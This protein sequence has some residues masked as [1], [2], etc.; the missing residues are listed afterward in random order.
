MCEEAE[1]NLVVSLFRCEH[2]AV[3]EERLVGRVAAVFQTREEPFHHLV[4][5]RKRRFL[6]VLS[7]TPVANPSL[8]LNHLTR[9]GER[10]VRVS[11]QVKRTGKPRG[12][13]GSIHFL[14]FPYPF[15]LRAGLVLKT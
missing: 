4:L 6:Q 11:L 15:R 14:Q 10:P 9:G 13:P 1:P 3:I 5:A 7:A 12:F 2:A 8:S